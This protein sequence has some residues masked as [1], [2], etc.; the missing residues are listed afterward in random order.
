ME[1]WT[2]WGIL[3]KFWILK[4]FSENRELSVGVGGLKLCIEYRLNSTPPTGWITQNYYQTQ[5]RQLLMH[6]T[7][8][9][10]RERKKV[11]C[12]SAQTICIKHY[13][14]GSFFVSETVFLCNKQ[15]QNTVACFCLFSWTLRM[16]ICSFATENINFLPNLVFLLLYWML[17]FKVVIISGDNRCLIEVL[18]LDLRLW[19]S[20]K[21]IVFI[22]TVFTAAIAKGLS[23]W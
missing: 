18:P 16:A 1:S 13:C 9:I 10:Y 7:C 21:V 14:D 3:G 2:Y 12:K 5:T 22:R 4:N 17:K 6:E 23:R 19:Y 8:S 20:L 11:C 15:R